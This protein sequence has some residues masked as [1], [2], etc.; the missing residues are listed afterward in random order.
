MLTRAGS[1]SS[2]SAACY[3]V[4]ACRSPRAPTTN[5]VYGARKVWLAL[6]REGIRVARCTVERLMKQAGLAGIRR[7]T[8]R[9]TTVADPAAPRPADLVEHRFSTEAPDRLW[10][11]DFERHEALLNRVEVR[12]LRRRVVAA[13]R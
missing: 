9:R 10:V 13:A 2:G 3:P 4:R 7:G 11:A 8:R 6:N 1:G 5:G 12:D